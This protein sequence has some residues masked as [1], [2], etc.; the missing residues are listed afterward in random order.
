MDTTWISGQ[1]AVMEACED[2]SAP[3]WVPVAT[4]TFSDATSRFTDPG[5]TNHPHRYYRFRMP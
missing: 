3:D 4:N 2:L 5:G 1:T